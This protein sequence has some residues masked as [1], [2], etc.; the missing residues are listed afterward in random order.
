MSTK[1]NMTMIARSNVG[2]NKSRNVSGLRT[3]TLQDSEQQK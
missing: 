1:K 2:I 3:S